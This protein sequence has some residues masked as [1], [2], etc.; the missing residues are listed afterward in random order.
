VGLDTYLVERL[1]E[2]A[3]S[4]VRIFTSEKVNLLK[5]TAV[6]FHTGEATHLDDNGSNALQLVFAWL[7]LARRLPHISVNETELDFLFHLYSLIIYRFLVD[8]M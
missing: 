5:S 3:H 4:V 7:E 8:N 1:A 6:G 2:S